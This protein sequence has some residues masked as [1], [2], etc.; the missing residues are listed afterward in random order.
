MTKPPIEQH[1]ADMSRVDASRHQHD[2]VVM[3]QLFRGLR[4][5]A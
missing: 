5:L 3:T 2:A 4:R 1:T